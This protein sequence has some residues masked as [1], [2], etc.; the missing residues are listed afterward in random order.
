MRFLKL[1]SYL[2]FLYILAACQT[3][4]LTTE[5]TKNI[6]APS[7]KL[8]VG[9]YQ[10]SP[11]SFILGKTP[12]E[13]KGLGYELGQELAKYLGIP[14]E[15]VIFQKN[16]D[17]LL[18]VKEA[19]VDVVFPNA[20]PDRAKDI[21]FSKTFM[22]LEQSYI[23]SV[24]SS[25]KDISQIDSIPRK[26]GVSMGSTSQKI[27]G[28]KLRNI[29]ITPLPNLDQAL[30][31]LQTGQIEVF[32]TNKGILYELAKQ[33]P[34]SR[35]LDGAWGYENFAIGIP[36]GREL[37]VPRLNEFL[38]EVYKNGKIKQA[39]EKSGLVGTILIE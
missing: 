23:V 14:F 37:A 20:T 21:V 39:I 36:K 30:K 28:E 33:L 11:T 32:A 24:N 4:G 17:A 34:G 8:R 15:V 7:G 6:L 22:Q 13:N 12:Q 35:I 27:L 29:T 18:A 2:C 1:V 16:A 19:Q 31:Q 9:V 3:S 26:I 25:I 38:N 10:G 5:Q